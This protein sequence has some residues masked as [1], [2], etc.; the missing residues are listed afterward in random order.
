MALWRFL[1][2][3][4]RYNISFM[5]HFP[6][7]TRSLL[8]WFYGWIYNAPDMVNVV[9]L[10]YSKLSNSIS[11]N[12]CTHVETRIKL[13][14]LA[15]NG[16]AMARIIS[17]IYLDKIINYQIHKSFLKSL[18]LHKIFFYIFS[19]TTKLTTIMA[20]KYKV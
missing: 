5:L 11:F 2:M 3:D 17:S 7:N 19:L 6:L 8:H 18:F 4:G 9:Q 10:N 12:W 14:Q 1:C 13:K 15:N 16:N 20:R